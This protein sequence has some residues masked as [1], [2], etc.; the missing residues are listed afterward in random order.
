MSKL[1]VGIDV[2]SRNNVVYLMK[3]DGSKHSNFSVENSPKGSAELVKQIV[4]ALT[5][6]HL[7]EVTVGLESTGC[8]GDHLVYF[9]KENAELAK[10][11]SRS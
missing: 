9:L 3:P 11:N 1:Y 10:F 2:S 8:Y 5:S 7:T 6:Y 4:K